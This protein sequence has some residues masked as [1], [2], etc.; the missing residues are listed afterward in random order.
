MEGYN[1]FLEE[2]EQ[3][4]GR[5]GFEIKRKISIPPYQLDLVAVKSSWELS[6]FGKMTR[7]FLVTSI[8]DVHAET[9]QNFSSVSTRYAL[10]NRGSLLPRGLVN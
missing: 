4:L 5:N 10:D 9:I 6:K 3:R 1:T 7:F 2:L 8:G